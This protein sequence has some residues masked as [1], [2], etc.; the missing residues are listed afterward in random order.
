MKLGDVQFTTRGRALVAHLTGEVDMSNAEDLGTA[1][2]Q[3]TPNDAL[4]VVLDLSGVDYL[5]SAGIYVIYG[6]RERL[7][8]RGQ[9][10]ILVIPKDA[11][12]QRALDLAG[13][14]RHLSIAEHV[15]DAVRGITSDESAQT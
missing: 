14:T 12:V 7:D 15:D 10:L 13:V 8:G 6:L 11:P 5:D 4:G 2:A 3:A 9:A 1:V